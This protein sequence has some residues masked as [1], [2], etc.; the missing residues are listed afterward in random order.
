M[1]VPTSYCTRADLE[2]RAS[3]D[4]VSLRLDDYPQS[5]DATA[6]L[7]KFDQALTLRREALAPQHPELADSLV[8]R[9][10]ALLSLRRYDEALQDAEEAL[11]I[12]RAKLAPDHRFI[13]ETLWQLGLVHYAKGETVLASVAWNEALEHAP[14]VYPADSADL[15]ELR[16][17]IAA[18]DTAL[19]LIQIQSAR[20]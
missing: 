10:S 14:R 9:S 6:A 4:A 15:V 17:N 16:R 13:V 18:P 12:R 5:G 8:E 1:A 20:R 3:V 2:Q 7:D 19:K 11:T